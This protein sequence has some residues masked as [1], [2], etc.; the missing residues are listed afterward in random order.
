MCVGVGV[1]RLSGYTA[2][3]PAS[4]VIQKHLVIYSV[5]MMNLRNNVVTQPGPQLELPIRLR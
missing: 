5:R 2:L 1:N 4:A 3:S